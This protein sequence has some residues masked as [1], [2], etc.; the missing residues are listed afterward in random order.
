MAPLYQRLLREL[1]KRF[2]TR[3]ARQT[4]RRGLEISLGRAFRLQESTPT[5][6]F[7]IRTSSASYAPLL[8]LVAFVPRTWGGSN[9]SAWED[10]RLALRARLRARRRRDPA[11]LRG[12]HNMTPCPESRS[13]LRSIHLILH[14]MSSSNF[15]WK[16]Y[17]VVLIRLSLL[18]L[19]SIIFV[20]DRRSKSY[21]CVV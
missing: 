14:V 21:I 3:E 17:E 16:W 1:Y 13:L 2:R 18:D 4:R 11:S 20:D 8:P 7:I 12:K 19:C 6:D 5:G 9:P 10:R 15:M